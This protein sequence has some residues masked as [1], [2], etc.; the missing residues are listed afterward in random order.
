MPI[1]AVVT[2]GH[3]IAF[4]LLGNVGQELDGILPNSASNT[5]LNKVTNGQWHQWIAGDTS[6]VEH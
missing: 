6:R 4:G 2:V 1:M 5:H 3:L